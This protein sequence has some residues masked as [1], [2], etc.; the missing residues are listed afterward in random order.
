MSEFLPVLSLSN[1]TVRQGCRFNGVHNEDL[2][3]YSAAGIG[4]VNGDGFA[5]LLIG[6]PGSDA[7]GANSGSAYVVFGSAAG[8]G[9]SFDLA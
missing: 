5:D 7:N 9:K 8:F 6:A 1:L 2:T 4:D 3:G